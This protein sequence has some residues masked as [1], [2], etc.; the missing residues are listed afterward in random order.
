MS[1]VRKNRNL[2][3]TQKRRAWYPHPPSSTWNPMCRHGRAGTRP[4]APDPPR[5]HTGSLFFFRATG[6]S[7]HGRR[8]EKRSRIR[9]RSTCWGGRGWTMIAGRRLIGA[10]K[11]LVPTRF[12]PKLRHVAERHGFVE[13][14]P[15]PF[16]YPFRELVRAGSPYYPNYLWGTLC[17]AAVAATLG[18]D[19]ISVIEFGGSSEDLAR[20]CHSHPTLSEAVK[21]AAMN[22]EKRA[23]HIL[24]R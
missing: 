11:A 24:N 23:L 18:Y 1:S 2:T 10:A 3:A 21:E 8:R 19:R 9:C 22:V 14:L 13:P 7:S 17:A 4:P 5:R 16:R 12:R 6:L 20:T 15:A